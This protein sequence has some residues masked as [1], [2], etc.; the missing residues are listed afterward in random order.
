MLTH[1]DFDGSN[2]SQKQEEQTAGKE[3]MLKCNI[4]KLIRLI[5]VQSRAFL[6]SQ[7]RSGSCSPQPP[8]IH[9]LLLPVSLR[10]TLTYPSGD[11]S[12][13][14]GVGGSK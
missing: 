3:V 11:P 7:N 8:P 4:L 5:S 2:T 10:P 9:R 13:R 12:L 6:S 14:D 1:V